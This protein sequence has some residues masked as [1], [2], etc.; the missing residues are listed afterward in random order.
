[1]MSGGFSYWLKSTNS[2]AEWRQAFELIDQMSPKAK[3]AC[4]EA[5][6]HACKPDYEA[7]KAERDSSPAPAIHKPI[8]R[9][10]GRNTAGH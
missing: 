4:V 9:H 1:M 8:P 5:L 2:G 10:F 7:W 3:A 6:Y